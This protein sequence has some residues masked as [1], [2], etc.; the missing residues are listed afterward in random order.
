MQTLPN[1]VSEVSK[2]SSSS[3]KLVLFDQ[4]F[5]KTTCKLKNDTTKNWHEKQML[6]K[7]YSHGSHIY[8]IC[9]MRVLSNLTNILWGLTW[10]SRSWTIH[11][12]RGCCESNVV[13][14]IWSINYHKGAKILVTGLSKGKV[15]ILLT[16]SV[17]IVRRLRRL[18]RRRLIAGW[19][20]SSRQESIPVGCVPSAAVTV[21]GV[22]PGGVLPGGCVL[23]F[24]F[25]S[26]E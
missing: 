9:P 10:I 23:M 15:C 20:W 26:R 5:R 8:Y 3:W 16:R 12:V 25:R 1:K 18:R 11:L 17:F 4:N 14:L 19:K 24:M 22:L 13:H 21:G 7:A 6:S 2:T